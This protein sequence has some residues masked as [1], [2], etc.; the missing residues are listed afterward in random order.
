[1]TTHAPALPAPAYDR[2]AVGVGIVHFG[3][4]GFLR[5]HQA[6]YLDRLMQRGQGGEWGI[7]AVGALPQDRRIID[8]LRAQDGL[9]AAAARDADVLA[10]LA[11][12]GVL[13]DLAADAR[14]QAVFRAVRRRLRTDGPRA[15]AAAASP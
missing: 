10:L 8:V 6:L 4:G 7:C 11:R 5:S 14:F 13:G 15:S 2:S 12:S 1:M 9:Y 3:V